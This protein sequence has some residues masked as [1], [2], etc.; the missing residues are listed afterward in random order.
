MDTPLTTGVHHIGLTTAKLEETADFFVTILGWQEVKRSDDYPT[1]FVSD[2]LIMLT[3]WAAK[4]DTPAHFNRKVN[5]GLHHLALTV[6]DEETLY[7]IYQKMNRENVIVEF[8]P[9]PLNGGPAKH[10]MCYEPNGIRIE[11]IWPGK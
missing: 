4:S 7:K 5:I 11:F 10:M 9:E 1:I 8:S 2:G 6:A 3:L